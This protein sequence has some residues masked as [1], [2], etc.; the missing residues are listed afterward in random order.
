MLVE[1]CCDMTGTTYCCVKYVSLHYKGNT[2]CD[3]VIALDQLVQCQPAIKISRIAL[4][5]WNYLS[6]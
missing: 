6:F 1:C 4:S 3:A 5:L 2:S